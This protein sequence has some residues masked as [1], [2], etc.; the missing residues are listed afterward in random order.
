MTL[1]GLNGRFRI[2]RYLC[3]SW[4]SCFTDADGIILSASWFAA[5]S[6][7]LFVI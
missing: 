6:V 7:Y 1:K 3:G 4:G 5:K 2:T